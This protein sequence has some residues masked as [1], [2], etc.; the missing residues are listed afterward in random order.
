MPN[1]TFKLGKGGVLAYLVPAENGKSVTI[2]VEGDTVFYA[3]G[4]VASIDEA[5]GTIPGGGKHTFTEPAWIESVGNATITTVEDSALSVLGVISTDV[6]SDG[7]HHAK[8]RVHDEYGN[9]V[10]YIPVYRDL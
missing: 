8:I 3:P 2:E 9:H 6:V 1:Q 5:D 4:H 7:D 10:G